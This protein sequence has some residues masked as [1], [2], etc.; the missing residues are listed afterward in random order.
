MPLLA[1]LCWYGQASYNLGYLGC[2]CVVQIVGL[3]L[4]QQLA[5]QVGELGVWEIL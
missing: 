1:G 4:P 2:Y 3:A 5:P